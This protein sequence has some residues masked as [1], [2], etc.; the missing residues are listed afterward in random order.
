MVAAGLAYLAIGSSACAVFTSDAARDARLAC[1]KKDGPSCFNAGNL[2]AEKSGAPGADSVKLWIHGCS[3]RHSPSCDALGNVKGPL[4]EQALV[5]ACNGGDLVSCARRAAEFPAD[6]KGLDEARALH[7]SACKL[8]ATVKPGM[9]AREI[10]G[11]AESCAALARMIAA[12]EGGGRDVVA[13]AKLDVLAATLR[14][15]ALYQHEREDDGKILPHPAQAAPP[16]PKK[17]GG[18]KKEPPPD[19]TQA[20]R[21]KFRR[22]Y[23]ARRA[24][25]EAWMA[26]VDASLVA[27]QKKASRGDPSVPAL[28]ALERATAPIPGTGGGASQCQVCVDGC[29]TMARCTGDDFVGGHCGHLRSSSD[30]AGTAFDTCVAECAAK[31]DACAKA[32]G[33]CGASEAAPAKGGR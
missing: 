10:E 33:E 21:E 29:G 16:P 25:R 4:R 15:E 9:S 8:S 11:I 20:D 13:A 32:C 22:E 26:S 31:A 6:E 18:L 19:P 7:H 23:E 5:D 28:S 2:A 3:V 30:A 1:D 12:G 17:K 27:M 14:N 24:A